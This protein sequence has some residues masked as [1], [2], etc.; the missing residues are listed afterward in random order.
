M[1][2]R[3][4]YGRHAVFFAF[5]RHRL[6][7]RINRYANAKAP[8]LERLALAKYSG[9]MTRDGVYQDHRRKLTSCEHIIT[10]RNLLCLKRLFDPL[11]NPLIMTSNKY[12]VIGDYVLTGG[13]LPAMVLI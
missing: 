1:V 3:Q 7:P 13:E 6:R 2:A 11:V 9:N 12:Q 4:E 10:N 8:F 5:I